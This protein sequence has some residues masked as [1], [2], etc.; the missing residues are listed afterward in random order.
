VPDISDVVETG[1]VNRDRV[2]RGAVL[3]NFAAYQ[4]CR[5]TF[6][7]VKPRQRRVPRGRSSNDESLQNEE[8]LEVIVLDNNSYFS[9]SSYSFYLRFPDASGRRFVGKI[10]LLVFVQVECCSHSSD[11]LTCHLLIQNSG[12]LTGRHLG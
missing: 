4:P 11:A 8:T 10:L 3:E 9:C 7:C 6:K 5:V 2:P 1:D 12:Q